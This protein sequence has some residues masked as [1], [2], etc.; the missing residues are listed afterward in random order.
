M[1]V[2]LYEYIKAESENLDIIMSMTAITLSSYH[3]QIQDI[4]SLMK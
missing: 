1:N 2:M 3:I 4:I